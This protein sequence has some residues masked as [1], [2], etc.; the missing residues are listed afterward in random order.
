MDPM[1]HN[2]H[3]SIVDYDMNMLRAVARARGFELKA[4][5]QPAAVD[6]LKAYLLD[7]DAT[8]WAL[9]RLSAESRA[10]LEALL[11]AGGQMKAHIF[12][13]HFGKPRAFGPGRLERERPWLAPES[14][15]EHL[16][17]MGLL[18]TTF[19]DIGE[20][21]RAQFAYVPSDLVPL[22]PEMEVV[23]PRFE[24]T[25]VDFPADIR[26]RGMGLVA[27]LFRLLVRLQMRPL[28]ID[29][30]RRGLAHDALAAEL[31]LTESADYFDFLL[32]VAR[33]S[34]LLYDAERK[35]RPN[36]G[37]ARE[38]LKWPLEPQLYH[39]QT[40]WRADPTWDELR[41][42]SELAIEETGW[43][44]DPARARQA[45]LGHLGRCPTEA[46]PLDTWL[47]VESLVRAVKTVDPDFARP[48]GD[49][50][51]WYIRDMATGDYLMDFACWD[52]VEARLI[53]RL[54]TGPLFWLGAVDLGY[55]GDVLTAFRLAPPSH[56][57]LGKT[58]P[59]PVIEA[60]PPTVTVLPDFTVHFEP[61][62]RLY[63]Q[64]QTT[65]FAQWVNEGAVYRIT[66]SALAEAYAQGISP[67]M[68]LTFL[69]RLSVD[70]LPDNVIN[71]LRKWRPAVPS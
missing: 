5:R 68:I 21:Y 34:E 49:Y 48:D 37:P 59:P 11:R 39:L 44:N 57:L 6:E 13:H 62:A 42:I 4:T 56:A 14:P 51:S 3:D 8:G 7:V 22:L 45:V 9:P 20:G 28:P 38:W 53:V 29:P 10:A 15:A 67:Q 40:A 16:W 55:E 60:P 64:F 61:G 27:D 69:Q 52:D 47:S 23:A 12:F 26:S 71:A 25:P 31:G 54:L 32:H 58:S 35:L 2:L 46:C 17:F 30:T 50:R 36:P 19:H 66:R 1:L 18:Y 43:R 63:E 70:S 65:R 24:V 41:H 33:V